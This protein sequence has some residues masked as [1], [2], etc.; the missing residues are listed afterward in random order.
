MKSRKYAAIAKYATIA[1]GAAVVLCLCATLASCT[2]ERE[3]TAKPDLKCGPE[4]S[5]SE[6]D[7]SLYLGMRG[8]AVESVF[9]EPNES[10]WTTYYDNTVV[11]TTMDGL[12]QYLCFYGDFTWTMPNGIAKDTPQSIVRKT[13]GDPSG[14]RD[15][16]RFDKLN[17]MDCYVIMSDDQ[18]LP[19]Q[20]YSLQF[21]YDEKDKVSSIEVFWEL[22]ENTRGIIQYQKTGSGNAVLKNIPGGDGNMISLIH[23]TENS[24]KVRIIEGD[25]NE[26]ALIN[27][28]GSY[29]GSLLGPD[30]F[31][32]SLEITTAGDWSVSSR[33]MRGVTDMIQLSGFGDCVT[34]SICPSDAKCQCVIKH[35]GNGPFKVK[36]HAGDA[37]ETMVDTS[38]RYTGKVS[39]DLNAIQGYSKN[40]SCTAFFEI[41]GSGKWSIKLLD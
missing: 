40:A 39:V 29:S 23:N 20:Y 35:R 30:C 5:S 24:I 19:N 33:L 9:G 10:G 21:E 7:N 1:I 36:L 22:K 27:A 2:S 6:H 4:F 41:T 38:G 37:A 14:H 18:R 13:Y 12:V 8:D 34:D 32:Y 26:K 16:N 17:P 28:D 15:G 11:L 31:Q 25:S 3:I